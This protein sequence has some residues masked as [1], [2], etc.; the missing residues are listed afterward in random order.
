M[1]ANPAPGTEERNVFAIGID[2]L[3]PFAGRV[4]VSDQ[5]GI[6][7]MYFTGHSCVATVDARPADCGSSHP[8]FGINFVTLP[9]PSSATLIGIGIG[10]LG[11]L[12]YARRPSNGRKP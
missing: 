6:Y 11:V 4:I 8:A 12:G 10:I 2:L 7:D 9:E 1:S 5:P 3:F